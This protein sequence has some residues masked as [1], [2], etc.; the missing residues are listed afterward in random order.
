MLQLALG[1]VSRPAT[2]PAEPDTLAITNSEELGADSIRSHGAKLA[3]ATSGKNR[4]LSM[5]MSLY[6]PSINFLLLFRVWSDGRSCEW[7]H[8]T[9]GNEDWIIVPDEGY[10]CVYGLKQGQFNGKVR[11]LISFMTLVIMTNFPS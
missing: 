1:D 9:R 2:A 8:V 5:S 11:C 7:P 6:H 3:T 10:L 4:S